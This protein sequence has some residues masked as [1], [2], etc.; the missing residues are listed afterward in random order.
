MTYSAGA[1]DFRAMHSIL[2]ALN[3]AAFTI[4]GAAGP[5]TYAEILGFVTGALSVWLVA[6]VNIWTFP[7]GIANA[8]FFFILFIDAKLYS[9]AWLQVFFVVVQVFG[10]W[11]WLKAGP[12]RTE[13][14]VA[15][16]PRWVYPVT[17]V[18]IAAGV[19]F[20]VPVL[21]HAHGAYPVPDSTSTALSVSAQILLSFKLI[22]NW[23]L[24][25][26]ADLIY[27]PLYFVKS[28]YFTSI[29]YIVFLTI[30]II[31][32]RHWRSVLSK[33]NPDGIDESMGAQDQ[34]LLEAA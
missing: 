4:P 12:N 26:I 13:L 15:K 22:E 14:K 31:G 29:L 7:V 28:L 20:L 3:H 34:L 30:C 9:D 10:W 25:I 6:K 1:V 21:H 24:W 18:G 2:A 16:T 27:I 17:F 19:Y 11:A 32:L 8:I 23:Y 33:E 5:T